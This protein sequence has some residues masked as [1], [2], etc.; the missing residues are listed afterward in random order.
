MTG[1]MRAGSVISEAWRDSRTG[2][3][4]SA[5]LAAVFV[6]LVGGLALAD[7][8]S[9]VG[10]LRD[11]EAY[12]TSG[13]AVQALVTESAIDGARCDALATVPG[14][15]ASGA[16]RQ[17]APVRA[18]TMP[19]ARLTTWEVTPGM[20]DLLTVVGRPTSGDTAAEGVW[21][22]ADLAEVLGARPGRILQTSD[23]PATV[24]GVYTWPDDGRARDLGYALLTP[25]P[26][27]G[28][29]AQCWS[30]VWPVDPDV[31]G[32]TYSSMTAGAGG[33]GATLGQL[34]T[35]LGTGYDPAARLDDRPTVHS[36]LVA[37]VVGL[38]LG[39][40]AA[41]MRRLELASALHARVRKP[42]LAWQHLLEAGGWVLA[43]AGVCA[44]VLVFG[45][46]SGNPDPFR[47]PWL[48]GLRTVAAGAGATILGTLL[49]VAAARERHLFRYFKDR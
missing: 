14:V 11:A 7:V 8:R 16:M 39:Y 21:V 43:A 49:G 32:L 4:R 40:T 6:L 24:A 36:G 15:V 2:T 5:L 29:F 12:R 3:S 1:P 47:A 26:A 13:S 22:S 42:H 34:N 18:L 25:V 28:T 44:A 30:Q 9:V 23:G 33:T 46:T 27:A 41:R 31:T 19:A 17:G 37:T 48:T 38:V 45:A 35:T 10:V 20:I